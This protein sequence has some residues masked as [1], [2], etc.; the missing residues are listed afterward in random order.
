MHG[1]AAVRSVEESAEG[2][3]VEGEGRVGAKSSREARQ[4]LGRR[5]QW[6]ARQSQLRQVRQQLACDPWQGGGSEKAVM[7]EVEDLERGEQ[8]RQAAAAAA[9]AAAAT[10]RRPGRR[11]L[12]RTA[13]PAP[14][15]PR[16]TEEAAAAAAAAA[17]PA[18]DAA[19]GGERGKCA[20]TGRASRAV[21]ERGRLARLL[22][23]ALL[24]HEGRHSRQPVGAQVELYE[25]WQVRQA[26]EA[27]EAVG[28][29]MQVDELCERREGR[30]GRAAELVVPQVE[31][32]H[33]RQARDAR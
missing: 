1:R 7:A 19:G 5:G 25:P 10:G 30:E 22:R 16:R 2:E 23:R 33:A 21:E 18:G 20:G 15:A 32:L 31:L 8:P 14:T 13:A 6:V 4:Q 9:I 17:A 3:V 12:R 26:V 29:E 27:V 24:T 11:Q 28:L